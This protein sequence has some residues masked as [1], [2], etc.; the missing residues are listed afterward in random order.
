ML[1]ENIRMSWRN[2]RANKLRSFLTMLGII[3]GVMAIVALVSIM[4]GA[5]AALEG[6]IMDLGAGRVLIYASGNYAKAG[7][8]EEE[9][10]ELSTIEGV[11]GVSPSNSYTAVLARGEDLLENVTVKGVSAIYFDHSTEELLRGRLICQSDVE[12]ALRVCVVSDEV[13]QMLFFG[14]DAVGKTLTVGGREY[15]VVGVVGDPDTDL[16]SMMQENMGRMY[17]TAESGGT[18]YAPYTAAQEATALPYYSSLDLFLSDTSHS[19][20]VVAECERILNQA[21]NYD[22]D[23]YL[24]F[25]MDSL[26]DLMSDLRGM[27]NGLLIGIASISLLV[28]GIGIMNMMLVT[29][30]ERTS[31][32]GLRKALGAE[33][34]AIQTQFII[35]ALFLSLLGGLLGVFFGAAISLLAAAAIG[36]TAVVEWSSVL[37]GFLFAAA[38]GVIFGWAPARKASRLNPIEALRSN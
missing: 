26:L 36:F 35:E 5:T 14:E 1:R 4:R 29:V 25:G 30:T 31:E 10:L 18:I 12:N 6:E 22:S 32:I 7:I 21:F 15:T 16:M 17:G 9:L 19:D 23:A 38:I 37:L 33:P 34:R 3:I 8:D 24:V 11:A 20:A 28:G 27:M 13:E 2:I